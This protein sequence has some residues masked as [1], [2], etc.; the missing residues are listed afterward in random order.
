MTNVDNFLSLVRLRCQHKRRL[1][2]AAPYDEETLQA[3]ELARQQ[4]LIEAVLVGEVERILSAAQKAGISL[5]DY[6]QV[7]ADSDPAVAERAVRLIA[8]GQGDVLMKGLIDSSVLLKSLLKKEHGLRAG[9]LLSHTAILLPPQQQHYYLLTDSGVNI[10]PSLDEK[11]QIIENAISVAHALGNDD[12]KVAMLCAKEKAYDKMPATLDAAEL[13]ARNQRGEISGCMIS[14]PLQFDL[15]LSREAAVA[16]GC[17]DPVAGNVD[18][19]AVPTIEV[20]NVFGK[21]LKYMAGYT[22]GGVVLGAKIPVVLVSRADSEQEKM[23]SIAL[24]CVA[25]HSRAESRP[26][27]PNLQEAAA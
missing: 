18:I 6:Q 7:T 15:A 5:V 22:Y 27:T 1:V 11:Q 10:A 9:R 20:G 21:A 3:V 25:G 17:H 16:K 2:V 24:A 8:E 26:A 23:L 19:F 4:Q 13:Q 12:P 14:G